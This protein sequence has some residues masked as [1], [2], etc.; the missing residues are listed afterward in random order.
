M[1]VQSLES[2]RFPLWK[3][4]IFVAIQ[5][6]GPDDVS[7]GVLL[8]NNPVIQMIA[9]S[10]YGKGDINLADRALLVHVPPRLHGLKSAIFS[11]KREQVPSR[12]SDLDC[13]NRGQRFRKPLQV[14]LVVAGLRPVAGLG[15]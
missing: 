3:L 11:K 2:I 10:C 13:L 8:I 12:H 1:L 15:R 7:N 9:H 14:R 4:R 6:T 5:T